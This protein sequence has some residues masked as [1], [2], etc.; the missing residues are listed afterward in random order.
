MRFEYEWHDDS[1]HWY[2]S[3]GNED[4]EFN[5]F[6]YMKRRFASINGLPIREADRQFRWERLV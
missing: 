3:Y 5:E 2:R 4:W 1:G 6:G